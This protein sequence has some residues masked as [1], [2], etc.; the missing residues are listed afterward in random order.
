MGMTREFKSREVAQGRHRSFNVWTRAWTRLVVDTL[1]RNMSVEPKHYY[2]TSCIQTRPLMRK[3]ARGH[4]SQ[5]VAQGEFFFTANIHHS[6]FA[7]VKPMIS[8]MIS[9]VKSWIHTRPLMWKFAPGD[10]LVSQNSAEKRLLVKNCTLSR[11]KVDT[12]CR[13]TSN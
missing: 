12:T 5:K 4:V 8:D 9:Y 1:R 11:H 6:P 3:F 2:G 10:V 13:D 7:W